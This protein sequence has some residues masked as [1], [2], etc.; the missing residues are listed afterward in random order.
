MAWCLP[1][2]A[3]LDLLASLLAGLRVSLLSWKLVDQLQ[4]AGTVTAAQMSRE[5]GS[6][7]VVEATASPSHGSAELIVAIDDVLRSVR[8]AAPS[9]ANVTGAAAGLLFDHLFGLQQSGTRAS[10]Y[11]EC[12]AYGLRWQRRAGSM[13]SYS[14]RAS[15]R[16]AGALGLEAFWPCRL[17][18]EGWIRE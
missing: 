12:E 9:D 13:W 6:E 7:F 10:R 11:A 17:F 16:H 8:S 2:D 5:L 15:S 18:V 3:E 4:I 1:G 14:S